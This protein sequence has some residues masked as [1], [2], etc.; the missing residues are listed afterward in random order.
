MWDTVN[1]AKTTKRKMMSVFRDLL[2]G[3]QA[4]GSWMMAEMKDMMFF[5]S[6]PTTK[7]GNDG[8]R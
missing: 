8:F 5:L 1:F 7:S 6:S 2:Q 4:G 3:S